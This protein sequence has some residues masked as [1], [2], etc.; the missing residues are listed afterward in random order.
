MKNPKNISLVVTALLFAVSFCISPDAYGNQNYNSDETEELLVDHGLG[1]AGPNMPL[2]SENEIIVKFN[3]G[4]PEKDK[5]DIIQQYDC[6][7]IKTCE[8][9]GLYL[10]KIPD[11][12]IP[13]DM[14]DTICENESVEYA[15]LNYYAAVSFIPNDI[16]FPFQW[17]LDDPNHTGINMEAAWDIQTGDPNVIIAVVDTGIAYEDYDIY[18]LAPDLADTLFVPGYDFVNN[19]EHPNDDDG[20]GT[21]VTGTIAQSTNNGVGVGGIAFGCS[22]M[23][24]KVISREGTGSHF[25]IAGGIYFATDNGAKVINMSL[26]GE[27]NSNTLRNAVAYAYQNGVTIVCAAGNGF[28]QGNFPS[29]PAA[30]DQYCIA[31]GATRYDNTK[32]RYSNT[33]PHIDIVAPG[34][35]TSVDQNGDG[36][37]DGVLQQ[38]FRG[39]P[40]D[41]AYWFF[42]GTSMAAPHVA[43]AAALIISN[44]LTEPDQVRQALQS[45]ARDSGVPGRDNE[46]GFGLLDVPAALNYRPFGDLNADYSIDILDLDI[47][48]DSWLQS[49][50]NLD[51]D[52]KNDGIVNFIDF[53]VLLQNQTD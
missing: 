50:E 23:P 37:P 25:D 38:T 8:S 11:N 2:C 14:V 27:G 49:E 6:T 30:Y 19:D 46:Y 53:A 44:G 20:H 3:D 16:Y 18:R 39:D 40:A 31:V 4:M 45:T 35:D 22:V 47:L 10:L 17:H 33:G 12:R 36:F 26:G 13:Q 32:T 9:A 48:A 34:G 28:E 41:F 5:Y 1:P 15:E 42:Q 52:L 24:V 7:A 51:A 43:G 21:H 29:Y